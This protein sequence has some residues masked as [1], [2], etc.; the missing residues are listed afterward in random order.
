MPGGFGD[1]LGYPRNFCAEAGCSGDS[2]CN[3]AE[4]GLTGGACTAFLSDFRCGENAFQVRWSARDSS[5]RNSP[6]LFVLLFEKKR[7]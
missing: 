4:A 3:A 6:I 1:L 2:D 7:S 5:P